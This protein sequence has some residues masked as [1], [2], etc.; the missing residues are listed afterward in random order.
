M[1]RGRLLLCALLL[2]SCQDGADPAVSVRSHAVIAPSP[3]VDVGAAPLSVDARGL[4]R[5]LRNVRVAPAPAATAEESARL[6]VERLAPAWRVGRVPTLEALGAIPVDGGTIV[7]LQP[8]LDGLPVAGGELRLLIGPGG[9]LRVASG[10]LVDAAA[11]RGP[12]RFD[13]AAPAAIARAVGHAYGVDFD[14]AALSADGGFHAGADRGVTVERA[15]ARAIWQPSGAGLVS[16]WVVETYAEGPAGRSDAWRTVIAGADG[17]V[18][19]HHDLVAHAPF[20]YRAFVDE[21]DLRPLDGPTEDFTPHPAGTPD[22]TLPDFVG[23]SLVT[24]DGLNQPGDPWLPAG[25]NSTNG[26][27]ADVYTDPDDDNLPNLHAGVTEPGVFDRVYDTA[28]EP[29]ASTDQQMAAMAHLFY[30]VN[31]LHDYWYDAGF[32]EAAGNAQVDNYDRGGVAADPLLIEAQDSLDLGASNNANMSTPDDGMSPRMQVYLWSPEEERSLRIQPGNREPVTQSAGFGPGDF[33]VAGDVVPGSPVDGC[34]ALTG[35][36]TDAVVLVDRGGC[37]FEQKALNIQDAGGIGMLLVDNA[38]DDTPPFMGD[39]EDLTAEVTIGSLSVTTAEGATIKAELEAGNVGVTM[40][41]DVG[42]RHEGALDGTLVAHEYGHYLHHRLSD[43]TGNRMCGA[44]S[45][46]WA[47]FLALHFA[48]REGDDLDGAFAMAG[49]AT[50]GFSG[51]P[52]YFGIRRVPYSVDRTRNALTFGHMTDGVALPDTHPTRDN[53]GPNSEVHNAG[54][55]WATMLWDAY[56]ALIR[57]SASFEEGRAKMARYI[58]AGLLVAPPQASPTETR[59]A[60]LAAA[61]AASPAD[62]DV[63]LGAFVARGAGSCAISPPD[64]SDDFSGLVESYDIGGHPLLGTPVLADDVVTCDGDGVLDGEETARVTVPLINAGHEPMTGVVVTLRTTTPG[65]T[66]EPSTIEIGDFAVGDS[67]DLEFDV[68]LA[69]TDQALRGEFELEVTG[70]GGCHD[71][72]TA[73][74]TAH[75]N[76]SD[77]PNTAR[78]D[79][80]DTQGSAWDVRGTDDVWEHVDAEGDDRLWLGHDVGFQADASLQ[81]PTLEGRGDLVVSFQHRHSFEASDQ[82]YDGGVIEVSTDDGESWVDVTTFGADPGYVGVLTDVSGNP[83]G[84]RDAYAAT[85][86]SYPGFDT[87]TLDFG[88]RLDGEDFRLRFRIGTDAAAASEGWEI[89]DVEVTGIGNTPFPTRRADDGCDPGGC[90]SAGRLGAG[91]IGTA[92]GVLLLALRRRSTRSNGAS[93]RSTRSR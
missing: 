37:S 73:P 22:G 2:T 40:S 60:I 83:L 26:N 3:A 1:A 65:V 24:V 77:A 16:A 46:G 58:V 81:S 17:R 44:L 42:V 48:L 61:A 41:R 20:G 71:S 27:N 47:D 9:E 30:V 75:L 13:V 21:S 35:E 57:A 50:R 88:D 36:V 38:G 29:D 76:V 84:G 53:G 7:R 4:P 43:C 56:V 79:T 11:P 52:G 23:P 90:C 74:F 85:N 59:D 54:E 28:A 33:D 93:R 72:V 14:P 86:P 19:E 67:H 51:D 8:R 55:V 5:L 34:A 92:I 80:F 87:V 18:L 62:H 25:A 78:S 39:D 10:V 69:A 63:L 31:W 89:D 32:T 70:T 82:L 91:E 12:A 45:E 68:A 64:D 6:L 49:Y 15:R 66:I